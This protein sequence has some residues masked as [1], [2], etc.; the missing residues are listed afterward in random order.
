MRLILIL[1]FIIP[2]LSWGDIYYKQIPQFLE[3]GFE[4][5]FFDSNTIVKRD[6]TIEIIETYI[7][8]KKDELVTCYNTTY[9]EPL[10]YVR[11][12]DVKC[13]PHSNQAIEKID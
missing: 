4:I 7:L 8:Q 3:E 6:E 13:Y 1:L 5:V 9:K 2:S 10:S 12:L 11:G